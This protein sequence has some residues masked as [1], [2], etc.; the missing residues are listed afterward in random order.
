[1]SRSWSYDLLKLAGGP[2]EKVSGQRTISGAL[3]ALGP[4]RIAQESPV[5]PTNPLLTTVEQE[6]PVESD[7][8][9]DVV[10]EEEEPTPDELRDEREARIER[11]P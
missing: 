10:A 1:M 8:V 11:S 3:K 7:D 5:E 4:K 2:L 6:S 9:L